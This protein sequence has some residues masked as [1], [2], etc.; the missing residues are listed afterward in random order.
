MNQIYPNFQHND[1][2]IRNKNWNQ[3][4]LENN[5]LNQPIQNIAP[6]VYQP[7]QYEGSLMQ[8]QKDINYSP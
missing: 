6:K 1:Q 8:D 4:E 3:K 7:N 5:K 2:N